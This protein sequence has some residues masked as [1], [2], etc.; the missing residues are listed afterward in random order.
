MQGFILFGTPKITLMQHHALSTLILLGLFACTRTGEKTGAGEVSPGADTAA[1]VIP[2]P[3]YEQLDDVIGLTERW[4]GDLDGITQRRKLRVLVPYSLT[5]YYLDGTEKKGISYEAMLQFEKYMNEALGKSTAPPYVQ[6]VFVPLSREKL[7]PALL[8]GYGDLIAENLTITPRRQEQIAFSSP[9]LTG[10]REV[11]ITGPASPELNSLSDLE[12][13][14]LFLRRSSS[15]YEH[16]LALNDSLKAAGKTPVR[17]EPVDEYLEDEDVLAMLDEG[18]IAL[19]VADEYKGKLWASIYKNI[20]VRSDLCLRDQRQIAWAMRSGDAQLK[21]LVD[22]FVAKNRKGTLMGNMLFNRYLGSD[23]QV[24][25]AFTDKDKARF[26]ALQDHFTRYGERYQLDWILLAAL[27]F[28]ES[29]FNQH[30]KS[31]AGAI[32]IMQ[33]LPATARDPSINVPD[34]HQEEQNIHAGTKVLRYFIDNF[35]ISKTIDSLNAG[36]FGVA[37]YNAGPNRIQELRRK[38]AAQGLNPDVWFNNVEIIA[39]REIGRETV[40]YVSHI[41]KYYCSYRY[42]YHYYRQRGGI[43]GLDE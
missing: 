25:E 5:T 35:F 7:I 6:V 11:I 1:A 28:Q 4:T 34:I 30:L 37:S 19:T 32:G 29:R 26:L 43:K 42:L 12:G 14:T 9:L 8:E 2:W 17:I 40:Q 20:R 38:A 27:G 13:K 22:G 24:R 31:R 23:A 16:V 41:Y 33:V 3:E 39:A 15:F 36:L 21:T 10:A 18:L